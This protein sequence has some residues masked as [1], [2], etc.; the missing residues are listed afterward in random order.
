MKPGDV[1][2]Y[3]SRSSE[4][5]HSALYLGSGKN[6]E[7]IV[8][9][10]TFSNGKAMCDIKPELDWKS[11]IFR[12][13]SRGHDVAPFPEHERVTLIHFSIDDLS[14]SDPGLLGWWNV[15]SSADAFSYLFDDTGHVG[16]IRDAPSPSQFGATSVKQVIAPRDTG[17]WFQTTSTVK[18]CWTHTG[19]FEKFFIPSATGE[20]LQSFGGER[21][22][23]PGLMANRIASV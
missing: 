14:L 21:D 11:Y 13:D 23:V 19:T 15:T 17:Y 12:H 20:A 8:A 2:C 1:I 18:C 7:G 22:G 6:G 10:H 3:G 5:H 16:F 9:T 4:Q